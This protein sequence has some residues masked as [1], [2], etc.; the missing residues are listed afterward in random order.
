MVVEN[1]G[2]MIEVESKVGAGPT[3]RVILP[4]YESDEF[5][6]L[7]GGERPVFLKFADFLSSIGIIDACMGVQ[8]WP[9]KEYSL[10]MTRL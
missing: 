6:S 2:C 5:E 9:M 7:K 8:S 1:Q 10:L 3:F 4:A